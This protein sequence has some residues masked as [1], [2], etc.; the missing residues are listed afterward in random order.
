MESDLGKLFIGGISWDTDEERLKEYFSK[1]GEVVEA[2]IMR[3]RTTGRARG[4]GFVVFTDPAVAERVIMDKHMIDGR[5]VEAKKAVPRDDQHILNRNASSIHGSPGPGHTK[6]IFVGGLAS[7]VTDSDF[8]K[9]FEQFGNITDVVVMYDHNTQRPRGFGFIT[10]DSEDAVDR[11][12]HKTFHELNGKMV[13][14]KRAV[15]KELSPGPSRS[16][17]IGYNYGL[18]RTN[19]F[20]NAYA[21]GYNMSSVRGF[22]MRMDSRFSPL[23]SGRSGFPTFGTTGYGMGINLEPGLS[24]SYGGAANFGNSPGYGRILSPYYNGNS[25]RYS[26]PIGYGVGNARNDSVLSPTRRNVWGNGSPN[27]AANPPSPGAFLGSGSGNFGVS[28]GNS[29]ANWGPSHVSAQGGG[30]ASGYTS[31]SMGYGSAGDSS[32]GLG[33]GGYGR[34]SSTGAAP[35]SSFAGSTGVYEGAYG[36]LYRG[37]SVYGD[38][39]W[40]PGTPELDGAGSFGYG[41]GNIASDVTTKSSDGYIGSYGVTSRQSNRGIAT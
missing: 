41:L 8:K 5:T 6:K 4:F 11:V 35:N 30:S 16:P 37:G 19:N 28:F 38:S 10:Y 3:D 32:Y 34:N 15:P 26:T 13:E 17:L 18:S 40:R 33:G 20:L 31:G 36:D 1:Y 27:T 24:P 9:Y 25:S 39:T 7:T 2:V 14:V 29:G 21:Q 22:G 23:A 12:L